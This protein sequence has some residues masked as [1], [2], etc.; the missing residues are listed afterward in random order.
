[1]S[2]PFNFASPPH[3][4][5]H[6]Y[7]RNLCIE[8]RKLIHSSKDL[9]MLEE[10]MGAFMNASKN[11]NWHHK[12]TGVYHKAQGEK[13]VAKVW[14]EFDRY[15]R[16]LKASAETNPEDLLVALDDVESLIDTF[17]VS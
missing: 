1:M 5:P 8:F 4:E 16:A 14:T 9:E 12:D 2:L 17:K 15:I 6:R 3:Q 13:V 11:M 10:A 7:F